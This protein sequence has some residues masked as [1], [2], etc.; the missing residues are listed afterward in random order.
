MD[1][2]HDIIQHCTR[3]ILELQQ[4]DGRIYWID[5]GIFDPWNHVLSAMALNVAGEHEAAGRAFSALIELQGDDGALPGQCGASVPLDSN[6]RHLL[7]QKALPLVDTN[8]TG[9]LATGLWHAYRLHGDTQWLAAFRVPLRKAMDFIREHQSPHG[10]IAWRRQQSNE[11][12][13]QVDALRTGNC[14]LFK[15]LSLA[16]LAFR[17]TGEPCPGLGTSTTSVKEALLHKPWRFDRTWG[18]KDR[19]AMDWYYPVLSGVLTGTEAHDHL[20]S[21]MDEFVDPRYG[22]RCVNDQPWFTTAETCELAIALCAVEEPAKA[23][24]LMQALSPLRA[25][26]GGYWM[27]WQSE[28]QIYWPCER[29]SW[30]AAAMILAL[31]A[32]HRITQAC[33]VLVGAKEL[34][35]L[36]HD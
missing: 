34:A 32:M 13:E 5:G 6:N 8:F 12:L 18:S 29:P 4:D 15:S 36:Q 7:A 24:T 23:A 33:E 35:V 27:G 9:F 26:A 1:E 20:M 2:V 28:E 3:R 14:S 10:E 30:T 19:Y 31:D 11:S 17:K 22:C 25:D 16:D 21:R